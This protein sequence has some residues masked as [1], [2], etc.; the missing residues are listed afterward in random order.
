MLKME[1]PSLTIPYAKNNARNAR[2]LEKQLGSRI[3]SLENKI[4]ANPDGHTD[5]EQQE[6]NPCVISFI[7]ID[8][9]YKTKAKYNCFD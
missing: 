3:E 2:N 4:N 5:A 7:F 6:P 9:A 1:I 8:I